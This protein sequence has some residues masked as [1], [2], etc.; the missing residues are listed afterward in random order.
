M[1][2]LGPIPPLTLAR[3]RAALTPRRATDAPTAAARPRALLRTQRDTLQ[4]LQP[5]RPP[6][7]ALAQLV[8]PRR[9]VGGDTV[10][11]P[12]R[13]PRTLQNSCPQGRH[14]L[15]DQDTRLCCD[16][17]R[18][19]PTL[20]AVPRARRS[21]LETC[22]RA[23]QVRGGDGLAKRLHT[24][25][26]APPCP[27]AEG[28]IAPQAWLVQAL[29]RQ[30]RVT[31]E[32]L[33]AWAQASAQRAQ[34]HPAVP[35]VQALPGAGPVFAARL[36]VALGAQRARSTSATARQPSAGIAPVTA[37]RGKQAWGHWRRQWP[38]L[39]RPTGVAW[40]AEARRHACWA[41]V[42]EQQ[43]RAKGHTHPAAVRARAFTGLRL[44][45]R[46]WQERTP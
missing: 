44:L 41:P 40:P 23:H 36:L 3:Y 26:T 27:P 33:A 32:A 14:G 38:T 28:S 9:R 43:P 7:R 8:D 12:H 13:L 20:N 2:S 6:L 22:V 17:L 10:R 24:L 5:Q 19:W 18:R 37:R 25:K 45:S 39:R 42:Y 35:L 46:C 34:R 15:P 11:S 1:L 30:R 31:W 4:P 16:C 21:T 29:G